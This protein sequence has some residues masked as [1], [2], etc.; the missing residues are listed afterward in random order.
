[1]RAIYLDTNVYVDIARAN[2]S[3][4]VVD[5]FRA[6]IASGD[7]VGLVSVSTL[8]ELLG[9]WDTSRDESIRQLGIVRDLVGFT[10]I[11]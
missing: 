8:E 4:S 6:A 5:A 3:A 11:L 7:V 9:R 1:M 10:R 2:I